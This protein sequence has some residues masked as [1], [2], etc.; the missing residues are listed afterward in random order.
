MSF[1]R[2]CQHLHFGRPSGA[3]CCSHCI[4]H[5]NR[6]NVL[7]TS[8]QYYVT[9]ALMQHCT[10][11]EVFQAT[12]QTVSGASLKL[13]LI[14]WASWGTETALPSSPHS[15][16]LSAPYP[17]LPYPLLSPKCLLQP[18]WNKPEKSY[19]AWEWHLR[20]TNEGPLAGT[21]NLYIVLYAMMSHEKI[22]FKKNDSYWVLVSQRQSTHQWQG[23]HW[24]FACR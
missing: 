23:T 16:S 24:L 18:K 11:R 1:C 10:Y 19:R 17:D 5:R 15:L 3:H 13:A 22:V 12:C 6:K 2:D 9:W 7:L 8:G 4:P 21:S 14:S 20:R